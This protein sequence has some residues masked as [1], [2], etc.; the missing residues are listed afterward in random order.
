MLLIVSF[1]IAALAVIFAI[2]NGTPATIH[3]LPGN[4]CNPRGWS[5]WLVSWPDFVCPADLYAFPS[6]TE[7][8]VCAQSGNWPNWRVNWQ[9]KNQKG[10]YRAG[11]R[12]CLTDQKIQSGRR[13]RFV[14]LKT[15]VGMGIRE[16]KA[17]PFLLP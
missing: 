17:P 10:F 3:F 11:A 9:K 1:V 7:V 2:Q 13:G 16:G 5:C 4:S 12:R 8:A 14:T 6:G 15:A